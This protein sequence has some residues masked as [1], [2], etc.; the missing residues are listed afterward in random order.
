MWTVLQ[1]DGPNHL[2]LW[3]IRYGALLAPIPRYLISRLGEV[4][5][6]MDPSLLTSSHA[7]LITC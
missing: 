7:D 1:H 3:L 6:E 2:G 5:A 4:R